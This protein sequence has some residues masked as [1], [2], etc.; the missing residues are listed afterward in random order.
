MQSNIK[1]KVYREA[2]QVIRHATEKSYVYFVVVILKVLLVNLLAALNF[3]NVFFKIKNVWK[4]KK[5][6]KRDQNKKTFF[7]IY[8]D[9]YYT[10]LTASHLAND[11]VT[12]ELK[13]IQKEHNKMQGH[14]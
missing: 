12:T 2:F 1:V 5:N 7:Y 8:R 11:R 13:A 4:I 3:A 10:Q 14:Q 6:V 9:S